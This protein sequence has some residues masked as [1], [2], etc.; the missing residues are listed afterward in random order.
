MLDT[1]SVSY[2]L[3]GKGNVG[4]KIVAHRPSELCVSAI[5]VAELRYG[6]ARRHSSR[7]HE[8]I[9]AFTDNIAVMPFDDACATTFGTIAGDLAARGLP[10]GDFDVLIAA[11][12]STIDA[13]LVTN[14]T[15]HFERVRG[16][17]L[18]NWL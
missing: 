2:A 18:E 13:T 14:N 16:L 15:K 5:T 17:R 3:R 1:D 11:H 12:A 7:L 6:A 4:E 9:D 10:I 8:I